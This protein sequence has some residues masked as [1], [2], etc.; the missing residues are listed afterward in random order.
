LIGCAVNGSR[1][2]I[3]RVFPE[4]NER[5]TLE[6]WR[7]TNDWRFNSHGGFGNT[8]D[9][10]RLVMPSFAE[11]RVTYG[12]KSIVVREVNGLTNDL[13]RF[14]GGEVVVDPRNRQVTLALTTEKGEFLGNGVGLSEF[15]C[16]RHT[17]TTER[18][19]YAEEDQDERRSG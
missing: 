13:P 14:E 18:S 12:A 19:Q 4:G 9:Y 7:A 2:V 1:A 16:A 5:V 11:S 10:Y 15:L 17:M 3:T 6:V 8:V